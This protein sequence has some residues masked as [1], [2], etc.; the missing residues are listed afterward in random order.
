MGANEVELFVCTPDN[1]LMKDNGCIEHF[2]VRDLYVRLEFGERIMY[3]GRA[4]EYL[5]EMTGGL[6]NRIL[7]TSSIGGVSIVSFLCEVRY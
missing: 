5:A 7:L 3:I 4:A 2:A 1:V 6:K